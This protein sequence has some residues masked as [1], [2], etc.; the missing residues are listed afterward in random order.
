M[1]AKNLASMGDLTAKAHLL[2]SEV[3]RREG[4][5]KE[6]IEAASRAVEQEPRHPHYAAQLVFCLLC[7]G[8][9][10]KVSTALEQSKAL[11]FYDSWS[12]E[13]FAMA[14]ASIDEHE[15]ALFFY[16]ISGR[17]A[18]GNHNLKYNQAISSTAIGDF[19]AAE[20]FLRL[21]PDNSKFAGKKFW[22]LSLI[23]KLSTTDQ[24]NLS[25]LLSFQNL[26]P[27]NRIF[28]SFAMADA[29]D[30]DR[31]Y[32]KAFHFYH[33]G[34]NARRKQINYSTQAE[35]AKFEKLKHSFCS[36]W[37]SDKKSGQSQER[38][39][40]IVGLPRTG[41]TL[42][43]RILSA[44]ARVESMGELRNFGISVKQ[45]SNQPLTLDFDIKTIQASLG[46]S[47]H[48]I[49]RHYVESLPCKCEPD[50][51]LVDK[52]P[53]NFL[54]VP[55]IAKSLPN[56]KIIN[57][58]RNPM[59]TCFSNY[60]QLFASIGFYSY[61]LSEMADYYLLYRDLLAYWHDL[62]PNQLTT[63]KYEELVKSPATEIQR[64]VDFLGLEMDERCL[65]FHKSEGQVATASAAQ[66]RR[67]IYSSSVG[68]WRNYEKHLTLVREALIEAGIPVD[69]RP[70]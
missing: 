6:S 65:N 23:D 40:F 62:F 38:V 51:Y 58:S 61:S 30:K 22:G 25:K 3:Y 52:N 49:G 48:E 70:N 21:I 41:T 7:N 60:R 24:E 16:E 2:L 28:S 35:K 57:V 8:E 17:K 18:P 54:Y 11:E 50:A 63:I 59:D 15:M 14:A 55:L 13:K 56:A 10:S 12:L 69:S 27:E 1:A 26:E 53:F 20:K 44:H 29:L 64:M 36:E 33:Q 31:D 9:F 66:A 45:L 5:L 32:D 67:P 19:S 43:D 47:T 34:N 68:K 4:K 37:I 42:V 39:I 46:L